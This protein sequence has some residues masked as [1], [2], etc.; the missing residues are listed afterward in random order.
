MLGPCLRWIGEI[1]ALSLSFPV[2]K[3]GA[4]ISNEPQVHKLGAGYDN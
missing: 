4:D 3:S 1:L 2:C